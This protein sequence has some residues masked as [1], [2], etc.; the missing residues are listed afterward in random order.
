MSP[1][2]TGANVADRPARRFEPK[3]RPAV[4]VDLEA[5]SVMQAL[6][7]AEHR[8]VIAEEDLAYLAHDSGR[9]LQAVQ[10]AADARVR[11]MCE[12]AATAIRLAEER[13]T[14]A[15]HFAAQTLRQAQIDVEVLQ[16]K[17]ALECALERKLADEAVMWASRIECQLMLGSAPAPA[18]KAGDGDAVGL[19]AGLTVDLAV[20]PAADTPTSTPRRR[21]RR[22]LVRHAS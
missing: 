13:A 16:H 14:A 12:H 3:P 2:G 6:A 7:E 1:T 8:A 10:R 19:A 9:S 17:H 20:K 5:M 11:E 21:G 22:V 18:P 15:L 4:E